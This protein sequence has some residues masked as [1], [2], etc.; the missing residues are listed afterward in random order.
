MLNEVGGLDGRDGC[1]SGWDETLKKEEDVDVEV[2]GILAW[3]GLDWIGALNNEVAEVEPYVLAVVVVVVVPVA[4]WKSSKSS[5]AAND[6][7]SFPFPIEAADMDVGSSS[8]LNKSTS[9]SFFGGGGTSFLVDGLLGIELRWDAARAPP[10]SNSLYSSNW[11]FLD[12][13]SW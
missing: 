10:S 4:L 9:F 2:F 7:T 11:A 12:G 5:S 3:I 1:E 13:R 8:K 6:S